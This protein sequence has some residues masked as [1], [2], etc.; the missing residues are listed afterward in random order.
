MKTDRPVLLSCYRIANKVSVDWTI[1]QQLTGYVH[2]EQ[3]TDYVEQTTDYVEQTT[4]YGSQHSLVHSR[5]LSKRSK[6]KGP[7]RDVPARKN[8]AETHRPY[9]RE[10]PVSPSKKGEAWVKLRSAG[11]VLGKLETFENDRKTSKPRKKSKDGVLEMFKSVFLGFNG[12]R[13]AMD[14]I[15]RAAK[16]LTSGERQSFTTAKECVPF[17]EVMDLVKDRPLKRSRMNV[18]SSKSP[19][20]HSDVSLIPLVPLVSLVPLVPLEPL[21]PLVPPV[22]ASKN[23]ATLDQHYTFADTTVRDC[24]YP[25]SYTPIILTRPCSRRAALGRS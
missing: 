11:D 1:V 15:R 13:A 7:A 3:T 8:N 4:D 20:P 23:N 14:R 21:E 16:R 2:V 10:P 9:S 17:K 25:I 6:G 12:S 24:M 18:T 5:A 22:R 19:S